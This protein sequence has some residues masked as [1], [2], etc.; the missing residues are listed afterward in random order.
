MKPFLGVDITYDKTN[1]NTNGDCFITATPSDLL[2]STL[3]ATTDDAM[4]V[5][6]KIKKLLPLPLRILKSGSGMAA[7]MIF[8]SLVTSLIKKDSVSLAQAYQNAGEVFW[9][10]GICTIL[11][12]LLTLIERKKFQKFQETGKP[13][14]VMS[15]LNRVA[16]AI[17]FELGVPEHAAQMDIFNLVYKIKDGKP[18]P[19]SPGS[20]IPPFVNF[21]MRVFIQGDYLCLAN[22]AHKYS[23]PLSSLTRICTVNKRIT[24]PEWNKDI[25][26]HA[27]VYKPYKITENDG[28]YSL[29]PYHILEF[30]Y[31]GEVWGIYFP[32]YELPV[33]ESITGLTAT[34]DGE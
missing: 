16:E 2:S 24:V 6:D 34:S 11:W 32:A 25:P 23:I 19:K 27:G 15:Q 22:T 17:F 8:A 4:A 26:H 9:I 33:M 14:Q 5:V 20:E 29:K 3:D 30:T 10:C 13:D 1:S 21:E 7:L 31:E 12:L 28:I 18:V